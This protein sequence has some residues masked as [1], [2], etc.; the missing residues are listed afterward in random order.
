MNC[1]YDVRLVMNKF[2]VDE[3]DSQKDEQFRT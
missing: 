1:E 3:E 2:D